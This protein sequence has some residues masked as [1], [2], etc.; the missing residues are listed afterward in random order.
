MKY[1]IY[2][3]S[4]L[5]SFLFLLNSCKVEPQSIN[6]G[7][8]HCHNCDMT[9]VSKTHA[10]EFVTKKGKSYMF[11]AAECLVWKLGKDNNETEMEY[12]LVSDYAHPGD[13]IDAKSATFLISKKIKS[14]MGANLSAFKTSESA[15]KAQSMH[16][17]KIYT[18]EQLKTQIK[19]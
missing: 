1:I 18:W 4:I 19:R 7:E 5:V 14:P 16:G 9:V 8:D 12:I 3:I 11:D 2:K 17:G 13:L 10:A 15:K 6:Y